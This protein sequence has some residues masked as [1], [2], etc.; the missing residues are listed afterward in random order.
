MARSPIEMMVDQACGV[1]A[2][3]GSQKDQQEKRAPQDDDAV[4][5]VLE[6]VA[7]AAV[8]WHFARAEN[9]MTSAIARKLD[10][11]AAKLVELGW[12]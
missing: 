1:A 12:R 3:A 6:R 9:R 2:D 5:K 8:A 4:A 10:G 11:A 7:N